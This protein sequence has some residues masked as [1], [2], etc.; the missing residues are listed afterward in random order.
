MSLEEEDRLESAK[1]ILST[2][3]NLKKPVFIGG[4]FND[5][6]SSKLCQYLGKNLN[7]LSDTT[8]MTFPADKPEMMID[9]IWAKGFTG[10]VMH[11]ETI[12][13]PHASDHRPIY[14]KFKW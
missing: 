10:K 5:T 1:I 12:N 11:K 14:V 9:Y 2:I 3:A 13:E 8:Q 7:C 4:D 6:P